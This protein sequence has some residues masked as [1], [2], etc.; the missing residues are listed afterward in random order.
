MQNLKTGQ[1]FG[2]TNQ[3]L[4]LDGLTLTDTEYTHSK[5]DWHY[6]ENPY[7]TFIL[8]GRVTEGNK[9][10]EYNCNAGSLLFHNWHEAHYNVKPAG[11]TRGFHIELEKEWFNAFEINTGNLQGGTDLQNPA[12]KTLMY[13]IFRESKADDDT[14][15]LAI[16]ALLIELFGQMS[17][18][19]Q[20][21]FNSR[22]AWVNQAREIL[23]DTHKPYTLTELANVLDIHPVHLSRGFSKYFN[24]NLGDYIRTL[25][26]QQ[27]LTLLPDHDLSLT[28]IALQCN[29]ADQSHFI[30]SFKAQQ[31]VTPSQYRNI[32]LKRQ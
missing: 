6:H 29:F 25:R 20:L 21:K 19:K 10:G 30:R 12:L 32:L 16:H 5:V 31:Q 26:V 22:P 28:D 4:R 27:A 18:V 17:D 2:N 15:R 14:G 7:F 9:K 8:Q 24:C 23:H 13:N 11:F 3:T 1:F